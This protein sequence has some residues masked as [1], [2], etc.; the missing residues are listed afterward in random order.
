[1]PLATRSRHPEITPRGA[2]A[3]VLVFTL[4]FGPALSLGACGGHEIGQEVDRPAP[5]GPAADRPADT[6]PT[7]RAGSTEEAPPSLDPQ[8]R[9]RLVTL[10]G[11]VV[12]DG[13]STVFPLSEAITREL[14][15]WAPGIEVQLGVSGTGGGFQKFCRGETQLS[16]A[17]RPIKVEEQA[18]CRRHGV[19]MVE[20]PIAFDGLS[21]VVHPENHW[22]RC[23]TVDELHRLWEPAAEGRITRWD[24]LREGWPG[25]AI[26][27]YGPGRDSGTLDY[28]TKSIVGIEGASRGDFVA[29][30]D[31]YL[32]AQDVASDPTSL[33]FF[34]A[35]YYREYQDVLALVAIDPGSGCVEPTTETIAEGRYRPLSRPMFLYVSVTA[36]DQPV[37][38]ALLDYYLDH[39]GRLARQVGYVPLPEQAYAL[40]R[41]RLAT[42]QPGSL[43]GGGSQVGLSITELLRLAA[44]EPSP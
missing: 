6:T 31:D 40:D 34:G 16:N 19:D 24:Q 28:F 22:A 7:T 9:G 41:R 39:A 25:Q 3:F 36:L 13:S 44:E 21:V 37:V 15:Q 20:L 33:G 18:L 10:E 32:I 4:V 35:A 30:E 23:M 5:E 11:R 26:T 12:I 38:R 1:M 17:S 27:L 14:G 42:R 43:F 2:A 29:S 8:T